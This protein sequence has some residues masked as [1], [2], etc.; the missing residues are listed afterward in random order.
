[1]AYTK[2]PVTRME[3]TAASLKMSAD[4]LADAAKKLRA[5]GYDSMFLEWKTAFDFYAPAVSK[6]ASDASISVDEQIEAF[7]TKRKTL[8][9]QQ[10]ERSTKQTAARKRK[11]N[12]ETQVSSEV[13]KKAAKKKA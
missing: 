4:R 3:S 11:L 1:M 7:K 8:A 5:E 12:L 9:E 13:K 2:C 6:T 10:M